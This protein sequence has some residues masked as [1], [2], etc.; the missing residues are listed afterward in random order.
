MSADKHASERSNVK[1]QYMQRKITKI[2]RSMLKT[3]SVDLRD[4]KKLTAFKLFICRKP[5]YQEFISRH[6]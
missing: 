4:T 2:K 5:F 1:A 6:K 3:S